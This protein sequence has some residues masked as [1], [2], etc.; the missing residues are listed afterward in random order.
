MIPPEKY[1]FVYTHLMLALVFFSLI[2][3]AQGGYKGFNRVASIVVPTFLIFFI[4]TRPLSGVFMDMGTYAQ[5]FEVA[6]RGGKVYFSEWLFKN[7][8]EGMSQVTTVEVFFFVCAMIY[9]LPIVAGL[10]HR[11][12]NAAFAAILATIT[13]FSFF[14][15]GVNGIRNGMATSILLSAIAWSDRKIIYL[16]LAFAAYNMHSSVAAPALFYFLTFFNSNVVFYSCLWIAC[17]LFT[18]AT[19]GSAAAALSSMLS[20]SEDNRV[21]YLT[22]LGDDK[23]GFRLDFILYGIVP[24]IISYLL[25]KAH[26][27]QDPFYRRLLCCYLATNSF[28]LIVMYAAFSNRFAY[29]SWFML[30]WLIIYPFIPNEIGEKGGA[31]RRW[32]IQKLSMMLAGQFALTYLFVIIIYPNR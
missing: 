29:L 22:Q 9:I 10:K 20:S 32:D 6:A 4:G 31:S 26:T 11:H 21:G 16:I 12:G 5:S 15:Y 17:L 24:V 13:S 2:S 25:S 3:Y 19:S 14:T 18:A 1:S 30:P 23:G 7:M 28:W 27:R 8:M